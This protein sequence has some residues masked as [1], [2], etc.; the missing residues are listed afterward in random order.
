MPMIVAG[1]LEADWSRGKVRQA[2]LN[3]KVYGGQGTGGS[4][5]ITG[6]CDNLRIAGAVS[7]GGFDNLKIK[8]HCRNSSTQPAHP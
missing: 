2:D 6:D 1:E 5:S 3:E 8:S 4:D 7:R